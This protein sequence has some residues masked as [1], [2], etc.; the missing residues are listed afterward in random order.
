M[1]LY[2]FDAGTSESIIVADADVGEDVVALLFNE[3]IEFL[4]F[5]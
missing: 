4:D 3:L 2:L 5:V 1:S